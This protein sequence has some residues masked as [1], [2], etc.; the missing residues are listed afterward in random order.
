MLTPLDFLWTR[1]KVRTALASAIFMPTILLSL[2]RV[3]TYFLRARSTHQFTPGSEINLGAG[4][5]FSVRLF[6]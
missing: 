4:T 6:P 5:A 1:F 2:L 3:L